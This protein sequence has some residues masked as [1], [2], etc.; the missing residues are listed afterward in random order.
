MI[1]TWKVIA[2]IF[3][4]LLTIILAYIASVIG[5]AEAFR[6]KDKERA[7]K[8]YKEEHPDAGQGH[9]EGSPTFF[10]AWRGGPP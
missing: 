10:I 8:R 4:L 3:I 7:E 1:E 6:V 5:E 9:Y 2:I